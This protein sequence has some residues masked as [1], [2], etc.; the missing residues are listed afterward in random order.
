MAVLFAG[1]YRQDFVTLEGGAQ[2]NVGLV[3]TNA[4][5]NINAGLS[6]DTT[7]GLS[8]LFNPS[9]PLSTWG[10]SFW[11][12][13]NA[14]SA[15]D[16]TVFV[17]RDEANSRDLF[18]LRTTSAAASA[19]CVFEIFNGSTWN[20]AGTLS[21]TLDSTPA[22]KYEIFVIMDPSAGQVI[23]RKNNSVGLNATSINT[24]PTAST[25]VDRFR[26]AASRSTA[27]ASGIYGLIVANEDTIGMEFYSRSISNGA[28]ALEEWSNSIGQTVNNG[29]D[30]VIGSD[31]AD[32][33]S[34]FIKAQLGSGFDAYEVIA[35]GI[36]AQGRKGGT[37][38][39]GLRPMFRRNTTNVFGGTVELDD[40]F[41]DVYCYHLFT[42]DPD[43][44]GTLTR[45]NFD[46]CQVGVQSRAV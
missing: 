43:G 18:R 37:G 45:A 12:R 23:I 39:A 5:T 42:E 46:A 44:G 31:T 34:T 4:P 19:S 8:T 30:T 33:R 6:I 38:P 24:R 3:L 16:R 21:M 22:N 7:A 14:N 13:G 17:A 26:W 28:G 35:V 36:S 40:A 25:A 11:Y 2:P 9:S 27:G 20:S 29:D 32:Q 10:V 1:T 41:G 15:N